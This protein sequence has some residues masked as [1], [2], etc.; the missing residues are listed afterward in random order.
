MEPGGLSFL[1]YERDCSSLLWGSI[2]KV[3]RAVPS[4]AVGH[5]TLILEANGEDWSLGLTV[6]CGCVRNL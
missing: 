6:G 4:H 2:T 3:A 5:G 1:I